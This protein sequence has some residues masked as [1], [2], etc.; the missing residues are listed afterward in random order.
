[1]VVS[2][3]F[4]IRASSTGRCNRQVVWISPGKAVC[5]EV[6]ASN[7]LLRGLLPT[8]SSSLKFSAQLLFV[9]LLGVSVPNVQRAFCGV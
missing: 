3:G 7:I 5:R 4:D 2:I 6:S 1:M 9:Y 8:E